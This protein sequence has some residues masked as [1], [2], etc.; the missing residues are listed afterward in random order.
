MITW[1]YAWRT[2]KWCVYN[3][4]WC[5]ENALTE[6]LINWQVTGKTRWGDDFS[7]E[8]TEPEAL[9]LWENVAGVGSLRGC[10]GRGVNCNDRPLLSEVTVPVKPFLTRSNS[11]NGVF[12]SD[13]TC[14]YPIV[15]MFNWSLPP[16]WESTLR[17]QHSDKEI[18]RLWESFVVLVADS[19]W[20]YV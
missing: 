3:L 13:R 17:N 7:W 8:N 16:S 4:G 12:T 6:A 20:H 15:I 11:T 5:W 19:T 2:L 9:I 1:D 14:E 18:N 10:C